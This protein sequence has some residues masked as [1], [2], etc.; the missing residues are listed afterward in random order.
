MRKFHCGY[1]QQSIQRDR[2]QHAPCSKSHI[3]RSP[4]WFRMVYIS[5]SP[6]WWRVDGVTFLAVH[7]GEGYGVLCSFN[8]VPPF[9]FLWNLLQKTREKAFYRWLMAFLIGAVTAMVYRGI[10]WAVCLRLTD[11]MHNP[12]LI[13]SFQASLPFYISKI[14]LLQNSIFYILT[15]WLFQDSILLYLNNP[16]LSQFDSFIS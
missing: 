7:V 14:W 15:N 3:Y 11:T 5:C 10:S 1:G 4:C 8:L 9:L 12:L 2:M 13:A 16:A 6:S